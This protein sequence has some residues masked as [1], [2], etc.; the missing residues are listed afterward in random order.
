MRDNFL[1]IPDAPNYEINSQLI[2]RN[3]IT[4]YILKPYTRSSGKSYYQLAQNTVT[5][6]A[7]NR[8]P[9]SLL[10]QARIALM[11]STFATLLS[12]FDS[13]EVDPKG[14][15]RNRR[16]KK[17]LRCR[18][19]NRYTLFNTFTHKPHSRSVNDLVWEAH[20]KKRKGF[21]PIPVWAENPSGKFFF[22]NC[23]AC[24]RFLLDK[25][26]YSLHTLSDYL[27]RRKPS[28]ADWKFSYVDDDEPLWN[29]HALNSEARRQKRVWGSS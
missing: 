28:I 24:A 27:W 8:Q 6:K 22:P 21:R 14:R 11:T 13:Y 3:K 15:C 16:T 29:K 17:L 19:G 18:N 7:I 10:N 12:P 5:G 25:L 9:E 23:A 26:H 20:G 4:G 2:V 1:T